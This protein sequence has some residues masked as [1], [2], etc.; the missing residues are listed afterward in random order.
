MRRT[1]LLP[2]LLLIFLSVS[3]SAFAGEWGSRGISR[4]FA[5]EGDLVFAADGRGVTT[6]DVSDP[7]NIRQVDFDTTGEETHDLAVLPGTPAHVAVATRR[8]IDWYRI[9]GASLTGPVERTEGRGVVTRIAAGALFVA[10]VSGQNVT[11]HRLQGDE[12]H[13]VTQ[14]DFRNPVLAVTVIG[15]ALYVS[16]DREGTYV[17]DVPSAEWSAKLLE[18]PVAFAR[19]GNT[20]WAAS[21]DT[22]L[23]AYDV[24]DA[25]APQ[26]ISNTGGGEYFL[27][28]IAVAGTRVFAFE[29]NN[30]LRVFDG[31]DPSKPALVSTL[32]EWTNVIAASGNRVY[33]AGAIIDAEKKSS[34][35]GKPLRVLDA[36]TLALL[37]DFTALAGPVSGVWTNGSVAYVVDPPYL[38]VIDVSK[39]DAP[40]ELSSLLVPNIQDRIRVKNGLAVLYGRAAVNLIDVTAPLQPRLL[41][42]WNTQGHPPSEAAIAGTTFV[43]ANE[44]SGFHI[45]DYTNYP[46]PVQIGGRKWHYHSIA[47]GDD[48]VY[49]LMF[50]IFL[51][52]QIANGKDA[53]DKTKYSIIADQVDIVPPNAPNP[54]ALV[55]R[56]PA[57]IRVYSLADRFDPQQTAFLPMYRPGLMGTGDGVAYF[58]IDGVLHRLDVDAPSGLIATDMKT[59]SPMQISVAGEKI[60]IADRFSL[61]V[62]GPDTES[63]VTEPPPRVKRRS[64]R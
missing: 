16:V 33:F 63:P 10:A 29:K 3:L 56:T 7:A 27:D 40:R 36:T 32:E 9:D 47:A 44:H 59:M 12:A 45:V 11:L 30:R 55:V 15:S 57:G 8:G 39:T 24:E 21:R 13:Y 31:A 26:V 48:A 42:T 38:R 23:T 6:Y 14:Y 28:G 61:R 37:G 54:Y 49:L 25:S 1:L 5:I 51:T 46:A 60:V 20:L 34:E 58:D 43:E 50:D 19:S 18:A 4:R 22:G 62:Y 64:V 52:V 35:T 41:A 53:V 2:V 17:Y